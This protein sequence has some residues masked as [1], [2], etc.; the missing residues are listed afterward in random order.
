MKTASTKKMITEQ[1][2]SFLG[3]AYFE[4]GKSEEDAKRRI[5]EVMQQI[6]Q[7][8][9]YTHTYEEL[10]HGARMAWRNN[11]R[12]IGRLFWQSL[13]VF[14]A[15]D[16]RDELDAASRIFRHMSYATNNGRIRP[17]IT[18]FP[19]SHSNNRIRIWNHQLVRYAGYRKED[20]IVGDS[21]MLAGEL[22]SDCCFHSIC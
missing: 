17:A 18:V 7:T 16:V 11:N 3:D 22:S 15:R 21:A 14:D 13:E 20:G 12:C 10:K 9:A 19:A 6:E 2:V 5:E 4:L 1:A 8:G